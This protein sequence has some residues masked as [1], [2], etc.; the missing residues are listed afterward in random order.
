M[1]VRWPE[2]ERGQG[3]PSKPRGEAIQAKRGSHPSHL[4]YLPRPGSCH[5]CVRVT[6]IRRCCSTKTLCEI[7]HVWAVTSLPQPVPGIM[8]V[9][10][11]CHMCYP[12]LPSQE[13]ILSPTCVSPTCTYIPSPGPMFHIKLQLRIPDQTARVEAF[14]W[15][16]S[17]W[18]RPNSGYFLL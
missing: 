2:A 8:C 16:N 12:D 15:A 14:L 9:P 13:L 18:Y 10:H 7:S 3:K 6:P 5:V 4:S 11:S 17:G 1:Y